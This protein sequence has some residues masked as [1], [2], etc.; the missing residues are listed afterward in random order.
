[1]LSVSSSPRGVKHAPNRDRFAKTVAG[2][3]QP[4]DAQLTD[5]AAL[6]Y[7][8]NAGK[9]IKVNAGATAFELGGPYTYATT[10]VSYTETATS[11]EKI[12]TVTAT[13]QTVTLP[14][15]VGNTAKLTF[16]L[17]VAGTL[18]IDGAGAETID[19]ALTATI[20]AQYAAITL[21]S[22][23]AGWVIASRA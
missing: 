18:V 8:G 19:D 9:V 13:G 21:V 12:V 7:A 14:T 15:A 3:Y 11:G 23:N 1:M 5:V 6:T 10:A 4:L 16:K 2:G 20:S 17:M 22:T